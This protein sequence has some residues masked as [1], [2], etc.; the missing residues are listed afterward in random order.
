[1]KRPKNWLAGRVDDSGRLSMFDKG[2][3]AKVCA[4][5]R[6]QDVQVLVEPKA[7][8]RSNSQNEYYW[9]V[10]LS[11]LSEWSGYTPE[12][13]HDA[14]RAKFLSRYDGARGVQIS[15]STA[16]LTTAE[17][18]EYLAR[19]RKWA[20]EQGQFIPLPNEEIY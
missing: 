12:E 3:F 10:V 19:V 18:E 1:M 9:G 16:K 5:L 15:R 17:F 14:M 6:G 7:K 13:M 20:A 8:T 2:A 11:A 4:A